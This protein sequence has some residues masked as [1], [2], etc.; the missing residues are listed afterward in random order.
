MFATLSAKMDR[1]SARKYESLVLSAAES[2]RTSPFLTGIDIID[3]DMWLFG[4]SSLVDGLISRGSEAYA[5][6]LATIRKLRD[7]NLPGIVSE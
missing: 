2:N 5:W 4:M 7:Y 3:V 6:K 1:T